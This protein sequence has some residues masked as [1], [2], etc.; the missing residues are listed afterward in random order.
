[1]LKARAILTAAAVGAVVPAHA[2]ERNRYGVFEELPC[3]SQAAA[4]A[5]R[6]LNSQYQALLASLE[7][8][9]RPSLVKAQ[10]AWLSFIKQEIEFIYSLQ[11]DGADGRLAVVNF[12]EAQTRARAKALA[13][14]RGK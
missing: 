14:W 1:M 11:G 7:P 12:N 2:C 4:V 8:E 9:Q 5:N 6:E 10:R 3:A 13:D